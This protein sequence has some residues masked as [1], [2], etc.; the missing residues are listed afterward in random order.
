MII[1]SYNFVNNTIFD[2]IN[3]INMPFNFSFSQSAQ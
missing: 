3:I 2:Y 1:I